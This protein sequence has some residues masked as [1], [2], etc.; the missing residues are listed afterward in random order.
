VTA[1]SPNPIKSLAKVL[2][3]LEC[4]S[5]DERGLGLAEIA[6]RTRLPKATTHRLL[7]ALK[8]IGFIDQPHEGDQYRLGMKLFELGSV[9]LANMELPREAQPF[10]DR[11]AALTGATVH[12]CVFDGAQAVLI[13]RRRDET[14][15]RNTLTLLEGAPVHCTSVGKAMLAWQP[16]RVVERIVRSGLTA[17]TAKT[18]TDPARL[19]A[20]L[21]RIRARG[22]ALDD[23]EHQP[24]LRC[25]A[26]P[27]RSGTGQVIAAISVSGP[28][29]LVAPDKDETHARLVMGIAGELSRRLG[30]APVEVA[31]PSGP[32]SSI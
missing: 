14:Q 15:T 30:H 5:R 4:F 24:R 17:F 22:W 29:D 11:L 26:A 1:D 19:R 13:D 8:A 7:A 21:A 28:D 23:A 6:A 20:E 9:V 16:D 3:V 25:I 27:I 10:V 2:L 31:V 18:V 32:G 12:L